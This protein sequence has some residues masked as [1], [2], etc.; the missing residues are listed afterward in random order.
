MPRAGPGY[1]VGHLARQGCKGEL[2]FT[3]GS[4]FPQPQPFEPPRT[5]GSNKAKR[6]NARQYIADWI[7]Y[8]IL[9]G[10]HLAWS[11]RLSP[12]KQRTIRNDS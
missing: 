12:M 1:A 3:V 10:G 8:C 5:R 9:D 11:Y 4:C 2:A 7:G 6:K